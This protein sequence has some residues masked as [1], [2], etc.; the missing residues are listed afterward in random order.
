M[1]FRAVVKALLLKGGTQTHWEV[2]RPLALRSVWT[3]EKEIK[4]S[5]CFEIGQTVLCGCFPGDL[6]FCAGTGGHVYI[7]FRRNM[8]S[9]GYLSLYPS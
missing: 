5:S 7:L 1:G 8:A 6:F 4:N 3:S 2:V 9:V